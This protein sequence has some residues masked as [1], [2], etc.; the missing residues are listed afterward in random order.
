MA[1]DEA[2]KTED[3]TPKRLREARREGQV[4]RT[5]DA[6]TWVAIAAGA[7][8]VPRS[9][10]ATGEQARLL[11]AKLP[12][13]AADPSPAQCL[14]VLADLPMAVIRGAAPVCLAAALGAILATA[15]QG[16]YPSGKALKPNFKRMNPKEGVKR[17]FGPKAAWEAVKSL[18]KVIVI[19]AVVTI[20]GRNLVP[21]LVG[22]GV[23]TLSATVDYARRGLETTVWAAAVAGLVLAVFDYAYQRR[24][25]MKQLKMS[26][27]EIKQ[28]HKQQEGDPHLKGA[29]RSKQMAMSRNRM[30]A[31]TAS[32]SVVL[33]NPTHISVAIRYLPGG[34]APKVV[35]KG[36]GGT[37]LK[38]RE[39]AREN[40][41]P[42]VEDKPL[43]RTLFRIC[44]LN[45]EI[46]AELYLAVARI[47]AFV[48]AAGRPSR[49]ARPTRPTP[50]Q[51]PDL[52]T[53]AQLRRRR[54][55]EIKAARSS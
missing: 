46:P 19:G 27:Y 11:L 33:V 21:D 22:H 3:P 48:M 42:V 23:M 7:A 31:A 2:D 53:R 13:V 16:V 55:N 35:A 9:V 41:I 8:M 38:I 6:P 45:D 28:E 40:R 12:A 4:A 17:M 18:A 30:M 39:V 32:A 52:P 5:Q 1:G 47:L 14:Q 50:T 37:A 34:G 43:A 44:E 15:A 54:R 25:V 51:V 36:A 10:S 20:M 24:T 26:K 29:I 49:T